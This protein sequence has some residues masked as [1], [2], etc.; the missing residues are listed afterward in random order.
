ME[1]TLNVL[2]RQRNVK[3][4]RRPLPPATTTT[5]KKR[6]LLCERKRTIARVCL[7]ICMYVHWYTILNE[8]TMRK[9]PGPID[10]AA[11]AIAVVAAVG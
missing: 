8:S 2:V 10:A 5:T 1:D 11:A 6:L 4:I 9:A 7:D 3:P